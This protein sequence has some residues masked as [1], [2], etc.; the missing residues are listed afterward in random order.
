MR[1]E[2]CV[3]AQTLETP[4]CVRVRERTTSDR[5]RFFSHERAPRLPWRACTS[6]L[7]HSSVH[8]VCIMHMRFRSTCLLF[9]AMQASDPHYQPHS[10]PIGSSHRAR[11]FV[12]AQPCH[13]HLPSALWLLLGGQSIGLHCRCDV[14]SVL[15]ACAVL[16]K[17]GH[18]VV[19]L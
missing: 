5:A 16:H 10:R 2:W 7:S 12:T 11:A 3:L 4:A 13:P 8:P 15:E 18:R 19:T 17:R 9:R 6:T 14:C 1:P